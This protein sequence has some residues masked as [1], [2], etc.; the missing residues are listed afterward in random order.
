VAQ[1]LRVEM[2]SA[3]PDRLQRW[4]DAVRFVVGWAPFP[5]LVTGLLLLAATVVA[6]TALAAVWRLAAAGQ[7]A[8]GGQDDSATVVPAARLV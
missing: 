8:L 2:S 1:V 4:K 7:P 3:A 5:A 6:V